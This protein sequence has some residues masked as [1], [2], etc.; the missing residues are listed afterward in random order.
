M[1][2]SI[3]C[4]LLYTVEY[5]VCLLITA[6]TAVVFLA[7]ITNSKSGGGAV[8]SGVTMLRYD[9]KVNLTKRCGKGEI[10]VFLSKMWA[11]PDPLGT[12]SLICL[13]IGKSWTSESA[14]SNGEV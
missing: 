6:N 7:A 2:L 10:A 1:T 13:H 12:R 14:Y 8:E 3:L 9:H 4:I 5:M 11:L